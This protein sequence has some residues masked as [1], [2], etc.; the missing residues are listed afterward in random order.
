MPDD[1][2]VLRSEDVRALTNKARL[3][4][5][6]IKSNMVIDKKRRRIVYSKDE[7]GHVEIKGYDDNP[8]YND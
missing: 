5:R 7:S 8:A 6:P 4:G 3:E 2:N 1:R